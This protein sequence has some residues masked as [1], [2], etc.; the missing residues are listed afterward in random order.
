[1]FETFIINPLITILAII[2]SLL[3]NNIVLAIIVLT[4]II[5][6][7]TS[8][9]LIRQQQATARMTEIQPQLKKLQEK[10]KNDREKLAQ[11]QLNLYKEAGVNP[12]G[13]CLPVLIQLPIM[14]ALY[15][16]IIAGLASTPFQV[17]DLA[18][19]FLITGLG[20]LVPL[21]NQWAGMNLTLPPTVNPVYALAFPFVVGITTWLQSKLTMPTPQLT[22]DPRADQTAQMTRSMLTIMPI[23]F[24][25]FSLS[26]SVGLSIYFVVSNIVGIIQ[27][28]LMGKADWSKLFTRT[29]PQ[30]ASAAG[31]P[32]AVT[33]KASAG[34]GKAGGNSDD[35]IITHAPTASKRKDKKMRPRDSIGG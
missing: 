11:E 21:Q 34:G 35:V 9:L 23:M 3:G 6:L 31:K 16:A 17:V 33:A 15:Q 32:K 2:Y 10:Y 5:R 12:L 28:T 30:P 7:V 25:F 24:A 18:D 13:G 22:G 19:R 4:V 20:D 29:Q 26:F 14:I 8:P 27:Y 1:M